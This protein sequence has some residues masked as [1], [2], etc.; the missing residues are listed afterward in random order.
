MSYCM[1]SIFW[2]DVEVQHWGRQ[3]ERIDGKGQT[4]GEGRKEEKEVY[5]GSTEHGRGRI[6]NPCLKDFTGE[7]G[8]IKQ[9]IAILTNSSN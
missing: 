5:G 4:R 6:W 1:T 7:W 9:S 2:N 8:K 3:R